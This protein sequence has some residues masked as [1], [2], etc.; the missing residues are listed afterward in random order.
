PE[1]RGL[2]RAVRPENREELAPLELEVEP[3]EERALA[4]LEREIVE[5]NDGHRFANAGA[6]A[7]AWRSCHCWKVSPGGSVSLTGTTG[8][9]ACRA[10][11]RRLAVMGETAWLL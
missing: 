5:P 1:Q 6:S 7:R 3:F 2:A 8:I 4:E 10:A 11:S 9:P